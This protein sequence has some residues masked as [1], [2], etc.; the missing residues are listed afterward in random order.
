[1]NVLYFL[2]SCGGICIGAIPKSRIIE[3][4]TLHIKILTMHLKIGLEKAG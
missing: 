2:P 4:K 1:M 3:S